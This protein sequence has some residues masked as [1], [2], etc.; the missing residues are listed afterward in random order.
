MKV[1]RAALSPRGDHG[2]MGKDPA[3]RMQIGDLAKKAGITVR[4][5][6]YYEE[7]GLL[8]PGG[9]SAGGFRLYDTLHL[10]RLNVIHFLKELGLSLTEIRDIFAAKKTAGADHETVEF[11]ACVMQEKLKIVQAKLDA[12]TGMKEELSRALEILESCRTC[13]HK[14]LLDTRQCSECSHLEPRESLPETFEVLLQ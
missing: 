10:K 6:R 11:L 2:E 9:H 13:D 5:I 8:H 12:L 4:S 1:P 7:L 3:R 14:V